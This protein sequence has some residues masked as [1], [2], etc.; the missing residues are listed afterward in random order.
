MRTLGILGALAIAA[1]LAAQRPSFRTDD[2]L[3]SARNAA[4]AQSQNQKHDKIPPG[5]LPPAGMCRIWIDGVPPGQQPAATDCQTAV[6]N[7]PANARVIWG[8]QS[9]FPG[10]GRSD[11]TFRAGQSP[12]HGKA[13]K[14][15]GRGGDDE[16]ENEVD[17]DRGGN[18]GSTIGS[19]SQSANQSARARHRGKHGDE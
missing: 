13:N 18:R 3:Q 5:Q 12:E 7:K 10:R 11:S 8:N 16:N 17:D 15:R 4:A 14:G 9:A 1:P 19:I 6:A 2:V